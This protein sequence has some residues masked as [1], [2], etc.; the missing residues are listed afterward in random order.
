MAEN[1]PGKT[2]LRWLIDAA[3][4]IAALEALLWLLRRSAIMF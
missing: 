3:L 2:R 1:R 4:G